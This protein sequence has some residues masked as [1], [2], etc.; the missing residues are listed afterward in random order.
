MLADI[1]SSISDYVNAKEVLGPIA[2]GMLGYLGARRTARTNVLIED[3]KQRAIAR[4]AHADDLSRRFK[5]LMDGYESRIRDLTDE[6]TN[7]RERIDELSSQLNER[8]LACAGCPHFRIAA[9]QEGRN[10]D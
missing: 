9:M 4:E 1:V 8:A 2:G 5:V 3:K 10:G 6:V 7:L